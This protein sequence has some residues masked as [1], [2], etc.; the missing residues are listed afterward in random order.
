MNDLE[1]ELAKLEVQRGIL[2]EV[3][4]NIDL[5][6]T[7]VDINKLLPILAGSDFEFKLEKQIIALQDLVQRRNNQL[8]TAT[9]E[10]PVIVV[11]DR[12]IESQKTL[13]LRSLDAVEQ[14]LTNA[15]DATAQKIQEIDANFTDLPSQEIEYARLER[16]YNSN[17]NYY[18]I[19]LEKRTEYAISEAGFVS[20]TRILQRATSP[21]QPVSPNRRIIYLSAFSIAI[22]ISLLI[23]AAHYI[24][25]NEIGDVSGL[26]RLINPSISL[27]GVIPKYSKNIPPFAAHHRQVPEIDHGRGVQEFAYQPRFF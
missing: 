22:F 10:N 2:R 14:K 9:S 6:N 26:A 20:D 5:E 21:T 4:R 19:L 24:L 25:H 13:I 8:T 12:Q 1:E 23:V 3:K 7:G 16:V 27:L 17:E 18:T 11:L 15:I